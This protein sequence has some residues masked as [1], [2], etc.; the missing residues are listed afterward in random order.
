MSIK[1]TPLHPK[2]VARVEGVDI[3]CD[4]PD[5]DFADLRAVF[6]KHSVII[7]HNQNID[8]EK[9]MIFSKRFGELEMM[10]P[11]LGNNGVPRHISVMH[12]EDKDGNI[13][14]PDDKRMIYQS[15]NMIWHSDSSFKS[16]P[17]LCSMLHARVLPPKGGETEF[18]SM[19]AAYDS[20][21]SKMKKF[22]EHKVVIHDFANTRKIVGGQLSEWQ[23][24][25]LPPV[26]QA[27]IRKNTVTNRKALF[28]G[29]HATSIEDMDEDNGKALLGELLEHAT[30]KAFVY[31]HNWNV[32]DLVIWDNRAVLHRGRPW[33]IA[34][35][36]RILHRT[37]VAGEGP[38]I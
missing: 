24:K 22:L 26:R 6:E 12:N 37:T 35:Y 2:F 3:A 34:N 8:D 33:D 27:L 23:K 10:A 1:V 30:Q 15:A 13:I 29:G 17:S 16:I 21:D 36:K 38:S 25:N 31:S 9:Q 20:L 19:R 4:I 32:G 14:P 11:H 28:I 18:A 5:A 7:I